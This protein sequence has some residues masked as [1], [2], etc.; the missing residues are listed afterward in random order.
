MERG[1]SQNTAVA[2]VRGDE[3]DQ[4]RHTVQA[5]HCPLLILIEKAAG[6]NSWTEIPCER[7]I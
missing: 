6:V 5:T 1:N 2:G 3:A 7:M 4:Q